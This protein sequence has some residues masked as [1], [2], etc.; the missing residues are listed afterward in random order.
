MQALLDDPLRV[1]A[2]R[3]VGGPQ[4][5]KADTLV[6]RQQKLTPVDQIGDHVDRRVR[7]EN[8]RHAP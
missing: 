7:H 5:K 1:P 2:L 3:C 6:Q 4:S 8:T